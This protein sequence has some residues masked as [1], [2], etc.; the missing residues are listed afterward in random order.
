MFA[1]TTSPGVGS[2]ADEPVAVSLGAEVLL[3]AGDDV[4]LVGTSAVVSTADRDT[5]VTARCGS[6]S[7]VADVETVRCVGELLST[8]ASAVP[9]VE[10]DG[11]PSSLHAATTVTNSATHAT[12]LLA[13]TRFIMSP[14]A[15]RGCAAAKGRRHR[16]SEAEEAVIRHLRDRTFHEKT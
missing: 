2:G 3:A 9:A 8:A 13:I 10:P 5:V 16:T 11:A 4:A 6:V 7:T 12:P 14:H 1:S 15:R